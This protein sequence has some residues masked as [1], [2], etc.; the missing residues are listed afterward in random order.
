MP[1]YQP[2]ALQ[3]TTAGRKLTKNQVG[4]LDARIVEAGD[5]L[6]GVTREPIPGLCTVYDN[7]IFA[8]LVYSTQFEIFIKTRPAGTPICKI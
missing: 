5:R 8:W 4:G 7:A 1:S 6:I 2:L 3:P